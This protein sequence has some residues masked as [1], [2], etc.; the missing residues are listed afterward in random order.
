MSDALELTR[1]ILAEADDARV[2]R[3]LE[4]AL[5]R[6]VDVLRYCAASLGMGTDL[7]MQRAARW[8]GYAY[9]ERVPQGVVGEAEPT[10][11]E[12]LASIRMFRVQLFDREVAFT[13]PDFFDV[14][15]LRH[16]RAST[17]HLTNLL[18]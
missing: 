8:A 10:R 18:F 5:E 11:L 6:E 9:Y 14:I 15:R 17:P 2:L 16:K 1:A 13:A 12:A 3:V 4:A 7:V